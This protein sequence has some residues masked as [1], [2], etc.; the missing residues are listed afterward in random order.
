MQGSQTTRR[1]SSHWAPT[2]RGIMRQDRPRIEERLLIAIVTHRSELGDAWPS[3]RTLS[4]EV[5][6]SVPDVSVAL[7]KLDAEGAIH[8]STRGHNNLTVYRLADAREDR[9]ESEPA[10]SPSRP[11]RTFEEVEA[12]FESA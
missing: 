6:A 11:M 8:R 2:I 3:V 7:D 12:H 4:D 1:K 10:A 5:V 9:S